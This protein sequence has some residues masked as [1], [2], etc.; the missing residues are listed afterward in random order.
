M[1]K[2]RL[3]RDYEKQ[4]TSSKATIHLAQIDMLTRR[5]TG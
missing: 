3:V 1:F 4:T 2:R 5:L